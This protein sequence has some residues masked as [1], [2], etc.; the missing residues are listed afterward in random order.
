M[1]NIKNVNIIFDK[2]NKPLNFKIL[3]KF[4]DTSPLSSFINFSFNKIKSKTNSNGSA[5]I[6][7]N[8]NGQN[9]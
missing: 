1:D 7:E 5:F 3:Y 9:Q 6:S 2:S 4:S 8:I